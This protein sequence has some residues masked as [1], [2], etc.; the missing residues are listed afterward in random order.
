M[1]LGAKSEAEA[2]ANA[3]I[4]AARAAEVDVRATAD[5]AEAEDTRAKA[6]KVHAPR[7]DTPPSDPISSLEEETIDVAKIPR[8]G[9]ALFALM[10]AR[11]ALERCS[12]SDEANGKCTELVEG[13]EQS[14]RDALLLGRDLAKEARAQRAERSAARMSHDF[15]VKELERLRALMETNN[16]LQAKAL[17]KYGKVLFP[18]ADEPTTKQI[19]RVLLERDRLNALIKE[20]SKT[21]NAWRTLWS[22]SQSSKASK[23]RD[24]AKARAA[25]EAAAAT[26][27]EK[28]F[29]DTVAM[30]TNSTKFWKNAQ[31]MADQMTNMADMPDSAAKSLV[32]FNRVLDPKNK[33]ASVTGQT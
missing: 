27:P 25:R 12:L 8:D 21:I 1:A 5:A 28:D 13:M 31:Q 17:E 30:A 20:H 33:K 32:G 10:E 7:P 18:G 11:L 29:A 14:L 19:C 3:A 26:E 2:D 15:S 16:D 22:L 4:R 9:Q 23:T 6:A 24:A